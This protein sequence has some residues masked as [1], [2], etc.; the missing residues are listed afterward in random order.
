MALQ[1]DIKQAEKEEVK[2]EEK[3]NM[4]A[5]KAE[6][7]GRHEMA[8]MMRTMADDEGRHAQMM[9]MHGGMMARSAPSIGLAS[10]TGAVSAQRGI[11]SLFPKTY[12]DW[13]NMAENI[14]EKYPD[15][16]VMIAS[17]N[18][19][20]RHISEETEEADEAKRWL[21]ERAG[22]LGISN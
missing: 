15:D 18:Y 12:G 9:R 3:Y 10:H 20:L 11:E 22:E 21:V 2:S 8:R 4:M 19:Q 5:H 7:E 14:K 13:V 17:V 16:T 6:F 1:D